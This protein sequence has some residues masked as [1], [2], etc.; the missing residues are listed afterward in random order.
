MPQATPDGGHHRAGREESALAAKEGAG[1][2]R[3]LASG[4]AQ[5]ATQEDAEQLIAVQCHASANRIL[6]VSG[7]GSAASGVVRVRRRRYPRLVACRFAP[8]AAPSDRVSSL[9]SLPGLAF[10][11][12]AT[13]G[14]SRQG[15]VGH[16]RHR[17]QRP[18]AAGPARRR[19]VRRRRAPLG[20]RR[21]PGGDAARRDARVDRSGQ[22]SGARGVRLLAV[23]VAPRRHDCAWPAASSPTSPG[24]SPSWRRRQ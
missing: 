18:G 14:R 23:R 15:V 10:A 19:G 16:R 7:K 22:R 9:P 8:S 13:R 1:A 12:P 21:P 24:W 17:A 3:P 20:L 11:Q 6:C 5:G 4:P 2:P